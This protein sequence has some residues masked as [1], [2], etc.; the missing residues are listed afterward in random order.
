MDYLFIIILLNNMDYMKIN[1]FV[2]GLL[3]SATLV[4][5]A[6][7]MTLDDSEFNNISSCKLMFKKCKSQYSPR[8]FR[9]S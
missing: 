8:S 1:L 7:A 9:G 5:F 4:V 2:A 3:L 6:Q